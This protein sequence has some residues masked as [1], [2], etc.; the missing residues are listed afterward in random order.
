MEERQAKDGVYQANKTLLGL[1]TKV[2]TNRGSVIECAKFAI[3][4]FKYNPSS[5]VAAADSV[6]RVG[7]WVVTFMATALKTPDITVSL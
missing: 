1:A 6:T 3:K 7:A 4:G 5:S 2:N